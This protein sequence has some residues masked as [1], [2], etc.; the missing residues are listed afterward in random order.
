[1]KKRIVVLRN[2]DRLLRIL[3]W[4]SRNDLLGAG[5]LGDCLGT[6]RDGMFGQFTGKE[7][8]VILSFFL[9]FHELIFWIEIFTFLEKF[10][11]AKK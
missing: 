6:L 4:S 1:M 10:T 9:N 3:H 2:K 8:P 5:V 11:Y 7:E